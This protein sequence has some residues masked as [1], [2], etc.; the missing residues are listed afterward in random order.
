M[1]VGDALNRL[2]TTGKPITDA[3]NGLPF[4]RIQI[5]HALGVDVPEDMWLALYFNNP[6][7]EGSP[8][9]TRNE[10]DGFIDRNFN[11]GESPVA[12]V[13]SENYS[14]RWIRTPTFTEEG[15]YRFSVT[16][17]DGV[18]LYVDG[19]SMIPDGWKD[20]SPTTYNVD[21][22]L[23]TGNHE[24]RLEYYQAV[25]PAQVRLNWGIVDPLCSQ[26][27]PTTRWKGEYYNNAYLGGSAVA[28]KDDGDSDSLN[29]NWGESPP[30]TGCNLTIFPDYFSVRWTRMVNFS[31]GDYRFSVSHDDGVR[32]WIDDH[33]TI[34]RWV[35]G[36]FA[37]TANVPL[38]ADAHKIV[39]EF[40]DVYSLAYINLSWEL[41]A[42]PPPSNLA[43]IAT[44][45][46]QIKLNWVDNSTSETGFKIERSTGGGYSEIATVGANVHEYVDSPLAPETT[47]TY[48]VR[49]YNGA[50]Y[51]AYS[52][53]S[54]ATTS[55]PAPST[56]STTA[57]SIS[58][59]K[60]NWTDNSA[61]ES[62]FKIE[63]STGGGYSEI[64]TVGANVREYV[65][66]PLAQGTTYTYRVRA[67]NGAGYSEYS[68]PS[69]AT[70][71]SCSYAISPSINYFESSGGSAGFTV[72]APAGC[73][74]SATTGGWITITSGASGSGNGNVEYRVSAF[75]VKWV[76]RTGT[77]TV[78]DQVHTI[79][80]NGIGALVRPAS[81]P[82]INQIGMLLPPGSDAGPKAG[83]PQPSGWLAIPISR[84]GLALLIACGVSALLLRIDSKES[85]R[86]DEHGTRFRWRAQG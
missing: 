17:D 20:Q 56:L 37:D 34:D 35:N 9:A 72:S 33:L 36:G 15:T 76:T 51:S 41:L 48:L 25:G 66:S 5:D 78:A 11:T 38:T 67:Y 63:R 30:N 84:A 14:V 86:K 45:E 39:L 65:D 19:Q 83:R 73:S 60:L 50:G 40:Y 58:Q 71:P 80:Q 4:R 79:E 18:R 27:P 21:V 57:I 24:I 42:P 1:S 62:G 69:S 77:I 2:L 43:A 26:D 22:H 70:T 28:V 49:A 74:W 52:N 6:N 7:L 23:G 75:N 44:S 81:T 3:R 8:V 53:P 59:I 61:T 54:S 85:R 10:G 31:Q 64:A 68:N 32:L 16:G 13:G 46:T 82:N 47:Y 12:G 55:L 29:F